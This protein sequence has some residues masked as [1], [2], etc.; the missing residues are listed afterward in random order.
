[1]IDL[2]PQHLA[3]VKEFLL[4]HVPNTQVWIY[5]SR[6]RG[7]AKSYA[8]LDMV[9]FSKAQQLQA[10]ADLKE[11]FD[12]SDLPFRVDLHVWEDLPATFHQTIQQQYLVLQEGAIDE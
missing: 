10:V 3:S 5:G 6:V 4:E 9:I 8:D 7:T 1:M 11:A 2:S 12:E